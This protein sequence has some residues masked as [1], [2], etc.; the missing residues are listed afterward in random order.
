MPYIAIQI[1]RDD[2]RRALRHIA[3]DAPGQCLV[4]VQAVIDLD[5]DLSD[6]DTGRPIDRLTASDALDDLADADADAAR[7]EARRVARQN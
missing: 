7:H 2:L 4:A 5:P 6:L 3:C 1:S